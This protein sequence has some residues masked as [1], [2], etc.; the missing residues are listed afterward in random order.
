[1]LHNDAKILDFAKNIEFS[2]DKKSK[3]EIKEEPLDIKNEVIEMNEKSSVMHN[4][5][6]RLDF[7]KDI[8]FSDDMEPNFEVKKEMLKV[9]SS[10]IEQKSNMVDPKKPNDK[11]I[12]DFVHDIEF[13]DAIKP[14]FEIKEEPIDMESNFMNSEVKKK[15]LKIKS[16]K[17]DQ[18]PD[19][20]D[21]IMSSSMNNRFS[22]NICQYTT[23][24][25]Y[26]LARHI[27]TYHKGEKPFKC[28]Y[29]DSRFKS[30]LRASDHE[31]NFHNKKF[32]GFKCPHCIVILSYKTSVPKHIKRYHSKK[33]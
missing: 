27:T 28:R 3:L 29:C 25:K 9:K 1:L 20:I 8:E 22:C 30:Q 17:I 21:P 24:R 18:S 15:T 12:M 33:T 19:K 14:K 23:E 5:T 13:S 2:N 32:K 6:K 26:N 7:M 4:E 11:E 16:S 31:N 10:R